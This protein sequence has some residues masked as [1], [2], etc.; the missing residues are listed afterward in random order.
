MND[1]PVDG[2]RASGGEL[3]R[4]RRRLREIARA[5]AEARA[6]E[7]AG[8]PSSEGASGEGDPQTGGFSAFEALGFERPATESPDSD[9]PVSVTPPQSTGVVPPF[10]GSLSSEPAG[11]ESAGSAFGADTGGD[12]EPPPP[13]LEPPVRRVPPVTHAFAATGLSYAAPQLPADPGQLP[14]PSAAERV[15]DATALTPA[16]FDPP[17]TRDP[18]AAPDRP[19]AFDPV[20]FG[21]E[22]PV[23]ERGADTTTVVLDAS[24]TVALGRTD[25]AAGVDQAPSDSSA[26]GHPV[27]GPLRPSLPEEPRELVLLDRAAIVT[28]VVLPPVGFALGLYASARGRAQ[29]GWSSALARAALW[30]SAAMAVV[31]LV[32]GSVLWFEHQE[33]LEAQRL[34]DEAAAAY[35]AIVEQS[36]PFCAALD[37]APAIFAAGDPDYG[38]PQLED[39]AGYIPAITNYA[40]LWQSLVPLAPTGIA[41]QV[42]SFSARVDQIVA[43][44]DSLPRPNRAG[45]L[46]DLHAQ[47][48]ITA[49]Q[50]HV[51]EYCAAPEAGE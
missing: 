35:S 14:P 25:S 48:D 40:A 16:T 51:A 4:D 10:Y 46:L 36:A 41:E 27:L 24:A 22:Q 30:V 3:R 26:A 29:R 39:P 18:A 21:T 15:S 50:A 42:T 2:P 1:Q 44:A 19:I 9:G 17:V 20:G 31:F 38:W 33:R 5:E 12:A 37:G 23:A 45:D 13:L 7:T 8:A 28:A 47:A 32:G 34:D 6:A 43:S 49:I 11:T